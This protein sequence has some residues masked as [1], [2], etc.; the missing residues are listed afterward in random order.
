[1]GAASRLEA[2]RGLAYRHPV[3]NHVAQLES[4]AGRISATRQTAS[5]ETGYFSKTDY[6]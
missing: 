3:A 6:R 5:Y 1:L 2:Y 4:A